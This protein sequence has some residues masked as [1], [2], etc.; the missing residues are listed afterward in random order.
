MLYELQ[1]KKDKKEKKG[2]TSTFINAV[3]T[4]SWSLHS[5]D[6]RSKEN[7]PSH[8]FELFAFCM[9]HSE[10]QVYIFKVLSQVLQF[11]KSYFSLK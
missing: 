2:N 11:C 8:I 5:I 10:A 6:H 1:K 7:I 4:P 9:F 3:V